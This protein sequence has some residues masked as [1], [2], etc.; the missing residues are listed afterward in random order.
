MEKQPLTRDIPDSAITSPAA[1]RWFAWLRWLDSALPVDD[2]N[3][4]T[5]VQLI[6]KYVRD[7]PNQ[8]PIRDWI[9]SALCCVGAE[10][11]KE[12]TG[13]GHGLFYLQK[14]A[15][16]GANWYRP[17]TTVGDGSSFKQRLTAA[18]ELGHVVLF[19]ILSSPVASKK[20]FEEYSKNDRAED[21][22]ERFA[23]LA[24][25][26]CDTERPGADLWDRIEATMAKDTL[27]ETRREAQ[28]V[29]DATQLR[30]TI[31]HLYTLAGMYRTS[32][33]H[34]ISWLHNSEALRSAECGIAVIR[35]AAHPHP[36]RTKNSEPSL[37]IWQTALPP[38]G[39]LPRYRRA[40]TS[41]FRRAA[42][43]Y[44]KVENRKT[45]TVNE[46]L[47][48]SENCEVLGI[49]SRLKFRRRKLNSPCAYVPIDVKEQG[50]FLV[51]F[52]QWE[53]PTS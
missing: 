49:A 16:L 23:H 12:N 22:C 41:G 20:V 47:N 19:S 38:W 4:E 50:R 31:Q 7:Q 53:A 52:W 18:H 27:L 8:A 10:F 37:R 29:Q 5:A 33:R 39:F 2:M 48:V 42:E 43:A 36:K 46:E 35:L 14:V 24:C 32:I 44:E 6:R 28:L 9:R 1:E 3:A 17:T 21:F 13:P 30:I 11:R 45:W 40:V 34:S 51:A 25:A 15:E 26:V